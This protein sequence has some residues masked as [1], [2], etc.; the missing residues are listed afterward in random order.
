MTDHDHTV[1]RFPPARTAGG[2]YTDTA[3]LNDIYAILCRP[4]G[5]DAGRTR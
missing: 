4:G 3:A 1:I 2:G 5:P